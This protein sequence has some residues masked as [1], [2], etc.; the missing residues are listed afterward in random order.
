MRVLAD[1]SV[2]GEVMRLLRA[3]GH[4]VAYVPEV[5]SGI[6]DDEVLAL[7]NAQ[8]RVL[9]TED[10]DFG[11]LAFRLGS[12]SEGVVLLRAHGSTT[13][14]KGELVADVLE[15]REGELTGD[16]PHFVVVRPGRPPRSRPVGGAGP[17]G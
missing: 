13:L 15:D 10:T 4:D 2:E 11:E 12:R 9:L 5:S 16:P 17:G 3:R 14:A 1:E 6:R 8:G 7:A